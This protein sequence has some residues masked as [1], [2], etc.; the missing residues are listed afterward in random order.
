MSYIQ[1]KS[2]KKKKDD[3]PY[4]WT[5]SKA[6]DKDENVSIYLSGFWKN[7]FLFSEEVQE[8]TDKTEDYFNLFLYFL[9]HLHTKVVTK[10]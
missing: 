1:L 3:Y 10:I 2:M 8:T 5:W 7:P 9:R 6:Y 4:R